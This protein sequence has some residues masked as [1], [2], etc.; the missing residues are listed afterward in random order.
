MKAGAL[1]PL[2]MLADGCL[3]GHVRRLDL[4]ANPSLFSETLPSPAIPIKPMAQ[5]GKGMVGCL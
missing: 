5:S 3:L 1:K 2:A 4:S